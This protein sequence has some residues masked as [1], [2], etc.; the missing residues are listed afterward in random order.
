LL[1]IVEGIN[2]DIKV[3]CEAEDLNPKQQVHCE[4]LINCF[5]YFLNPWTTA[6]DTHEMV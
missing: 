2:T 3:S 5:P 1:H 6:W 4:E